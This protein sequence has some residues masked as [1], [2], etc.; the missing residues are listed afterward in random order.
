VASLQQRK[1]RL[2]SAKKPEVFKLTAPR[3]NPERDLQASLIDLFALLVRPGDAVIFAVP[4]GE[5]RDP[6][7]AAILSGGAIDHHSPDEVFLVP[8]GQGV[9]SGAVDLVLLAPK[10]VSVL[11]EVKVPGL[12]A[13]PFFKGRN[14]G[15]LSR[16][17]KIFRE[18]AVRLEHRHEVV[19]SPEEFRAVLLKYAVPIRTARISP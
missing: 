18:A 19:Y 8:R 1:L 15:T 2:R 4:N 5:K 3:G 13:T 10:G 9:L 16:P 14:K 17:Q 6:T 11:I 12:P 7:T